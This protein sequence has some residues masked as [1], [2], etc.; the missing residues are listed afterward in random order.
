MCVAAPQ[1]KSITDVL[2]TVQNKIQAFD[3][4]FKGVIHYKTDGS[5]ISFYYA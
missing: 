1:Q 5:S 4:I 3:T 2:N